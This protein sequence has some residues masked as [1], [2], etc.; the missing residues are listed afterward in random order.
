[1]NEQTPLRLVTK[2][3]ADH[4]EKVASVVHQLEQWLE[5]AKAGEIEGIAVAALYSDGACGCGFSASASYYRL[6]GAITDLQHTYASKH[7]E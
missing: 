7:N 5:K 4:D 6:L 3:E 1:M 2:T